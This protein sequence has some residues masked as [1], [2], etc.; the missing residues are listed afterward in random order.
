MK[1]GKARGRK[2]EIVHF[3]CT[4]KYDFFLGMKLEH[5]DK[6]QTEK[7]DMKEILNVFEAKD[8]SIRY[9]VII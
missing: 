9:C 3:S 8:F 1:C 6:K 5:D 2:A 4:R 7:Y